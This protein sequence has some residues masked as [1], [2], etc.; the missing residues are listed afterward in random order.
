MPVFKT[1]L[2]GQDSL[3]TT[4]RESYQDLPHLFI[5]GP[6]GCGKTTFINLQNLVKLKKNKI[7]HS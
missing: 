7:T 5:C 6:P 4:I 3:F 1:Q 2:Y